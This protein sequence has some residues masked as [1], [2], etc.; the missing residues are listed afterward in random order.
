MAGE[1]EGKPSPLGIRKPKLLL[2]EGR[3]EEKIF[4]EMLRVCGL[5]DVQVLNY[6]GKSKLQDFLQA[7]KGAT[8]FAGVRV[9]AVTCDADNDHAS[10]VQQ[11]KNAIARAGFP[12]GLR[13]KIFVIPAPGRPG[14]LEDLFLDALK[15]SPVHRCI[16]LFMECIKAAGATPQP[17]AKARIHAWL[18]TRDR[19]DLRLGDA[20]QGGAV[21]LNHPAFA[22][23]LNFLRSLD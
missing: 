1:H 7:V 8:G 19:P 5:T 22:G 2:G 10:A 17:E 11:L 13:V 15:E 12:P 6:G 3:E 14:M 16:N 21:D 9:L 4:G 18:A 23:F 20:V